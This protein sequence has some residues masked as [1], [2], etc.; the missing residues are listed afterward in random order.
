MTP[1]LTYPT[2]PPTFRSEIV[3]RGGGGGY[4][5]PL[6]LYRTHL[7]EGASPPLLVT[8]FKN[9][10]HDP[11]R[12]EDL[13]QVIEEHRNKVSSFNSKIDLENVYEVSNTSMVNTF[14]VSD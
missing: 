7:S 8:D 2:P 1:N 14:S 6:G 3:D 10:T 11:S 9:S 12:Q 5:G 4:A 13:F